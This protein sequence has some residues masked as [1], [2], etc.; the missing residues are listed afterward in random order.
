MSMKCLVTGAAG[1]IGSHLAERLLKDGH[2]VVGLDAFTDAYPASFKEANISRIRTGG[3]FHLVRGDLAEADLERLV[4][5][6]DVV[7]HLAAQAGVRSSWG[8]DFQI[9]LS[10]NVLATQRL[11]EACRD[12]PLRSFVYASSSSVYGEQDAYPTPEEVLPRPLSPYGVTKLAAEHLCLLYW[13]NHQVPTVSL[14]FFTVYG[15]R[16]RPDMAFY[17]FLE[18]SLK[19]EPITVYGDG[20]Q[21]RDFTYVADIVEAS[22]MAAEAGRQGS[23]Y[24]IGGGSR[25]T[26][27]E[28]LETIA[29][30]TGRRPG[31]RFQEAQKGDARHTWADLTRAKEE[32]GY[33]P[34]VSLREG[35]AKEFEWM[36]E[37]LGG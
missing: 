12:R 35:I 5:G 25:A 28:A 30:V 34:K 36:V 37:M 1:F 33:Q 21:S 4:D 8:R 32:L 7:F 13:R 10:R 19:G 20:E 23:V 27:L 29:E 24:N 18:A 15:P 3:E 2:R 16:Q 6:V 26:L 9:Y 14:R 31:V 17:R 11:L 22:L